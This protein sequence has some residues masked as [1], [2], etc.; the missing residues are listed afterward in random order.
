MPCYSPLSGYKSQLTTKNGKRKLTFSNKAGYADLPLT[1]P[2]GQCIGCRLERSRQWA[3]RLTHEAQMHELSVFVTL[4]YSPENEPEGRT[5]VK[6]HFQSFMKRLRKSHGSKI[7]Y[8]HCGEYGETTG[9]PHYH[10]ILFGVDFADKK[11]HSKNPQG[12]TI[13]TSATL[14]KIWGLGF[15]TI[16]A[17]NF[18]TC[19]YVARYVMKKRTGEQAPAHYETLNLATGE[20]VHRLPEYATM[21]LK[22]GIGA[23]WYARYAK[24][25]FP[26]DNVVVRGKETH[27]PRYYSTLLARQSESAA[28]KIKYQRIRRAAKHKADQ[29]PERLRARL[30]CKTAQ[31]QSLK[32]TI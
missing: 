6:A 5:L 20:I 28:Q 27:P 13:W 22:P 2:C 9:R 24:D 29:T 16:G 15:C 32:R 8:Y 26:S 11:K 30:I 31:I 7:R 21:S 4:T 19:A 17:V 23:D 14:D 3:I 25:V 12:N 1:V 18:E 10:A